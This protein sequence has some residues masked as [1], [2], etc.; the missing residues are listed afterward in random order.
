MITPMQISIAD[1]T[2]SMLLDIELGRLY[3]D[4]V[5]T[6][7]LQANRCPEPEVVAVMFRA[8]KAGDCVIDAGANVGF[9][10]VLMSKLVG[11]TGHVISIEPDLRNLKV[12]R[13]N[14]DINECQNVD[15][16]SRPLSCDESLL[17]FYQNEENGQSSLFAT[18][19]DVASSEERT[20]TFDLIIAE[21]KPTFLKMDIEGA[22]YEA[23]RGCSHYFDAIVCEVNPEALKRADSSPEELIEHMRGDGYGA[24][25]LREDG[26]LPSLIRHDQK[27][28]ITRP[29]T[30]LLF[31]DAAGIMR[32]WPEIEA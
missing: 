26:S 6:Q 25:L 14:L 9:F 28:K 31:T 10:S 1:R 2:V 17:N 5:L 32:L 7:Y 4:A 18:I 30:N 19:R 20:T 13:K 29:N 12:M 16:V 27:I 21:D 15:V 22:E 23:M 3:S 11:P 24:Y 8:C